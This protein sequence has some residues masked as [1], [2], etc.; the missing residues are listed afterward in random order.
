MTALGREDMENQNRIAE[1][2]GLKPLVRLLRQPKTTGK[3]LLSVI[4]TLGTLCLGKKQQHRY[5]YVL[6]G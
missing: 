4:K 3:V 5:S 2:D 6:L 1:Q